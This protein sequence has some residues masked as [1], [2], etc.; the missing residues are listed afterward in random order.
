MRST[1]LGEISVPPLA[2]AECAAIICSGVTASSWPIDSDA[3]EYDDQTFTGRNMPPISPGRPD[4]GTRPN[5]KVAIVAKSSAFDSRPPIRD[6][7]MLLDFTS[8]SP[9]LNRPYGCVS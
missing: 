6:M 4:P 2:S 9:T 3:L 1:S 8:T 5:P 7:P